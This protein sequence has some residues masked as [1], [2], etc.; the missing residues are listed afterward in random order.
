MECGLLPSRGKRESYGHRRWPSSQVAGELIVLCLMGWKGKRLQRPG[1]CVNDPGAEG[2]WFG[3]G[4]FN[5]LEFVSSECVFPPI[6]VSR[7]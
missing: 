7:W 4:G 1:M 5:P 3:A 6:R 2:A